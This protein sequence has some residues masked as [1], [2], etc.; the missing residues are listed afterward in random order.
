MDRSD[1]R[2]YWRIAI[3]GGTAATVIGNLLT[4]IDLGAVGRAT[5]SFVAATI[6][7]LHDVAAKPI[8][9]RA[10][11]WLW[12]GVGT[13]AIAL[14]AYRQRLVSWADWGRAR[15]GN[16]PGADSE[17]D[18]FTERVGALFRKSADGASRELRFVVDH[19]AA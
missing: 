15:L 19:I 12:L 5:P 16:A 18:E 3:V 17:A 13:L 7:W 9:L 2:T 14:L 1:K 4:H 6:S 11:L 10:P 8:G